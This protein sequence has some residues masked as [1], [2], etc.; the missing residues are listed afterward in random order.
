LSLNVAGLAVVPDAVPDVFVVRPPVA[1]VGL[2]YVGL[3]TG[4]ALA[5]RGF[6]VIGIDSSLPR[7]QEIREGRA[8][9]LERDRGR[10]AEA[11]AADQLRL[12]GTA[13][14]MREADAVL[15]C[16][17][18]PVDE[19]LD[20]DLRALE[21]ACATVVEHARAGQLI[22]LTST[23]YVG[24]TRR[25]LV[26]PLRER[27]L[28]AGEDVFLAF[29]PERINP[30]DI[31]HE[32]ESVPRVFGAVTEACAARTREVLQDITPVLHEVPS[33]EHA[34]LTKL[35]E[36]TYRAVNIALA[37]EMA[38][39]ARHYG[40]DPIVVTNAAATKPYGF[41]AHF[42][43]P[44]VG[45][46]CIP[47]DPYYL[48]KPLAEEGHASPLIE[49]AMRGIAERPD[50]V[51]DRA[52]LMLSADGLEIGGARVLVVGVTYKPGVRDVRESVSIKILKELI[53]RGADVS[54]YDP[55]VPI[56]R[57]RSDPRLSS[58]PYPDP[59]DY[60]AVI[61]TTQQ[62]DIDYSW[63]E[64]CDRVLDCTYRMR[65][66]GDQVLNVL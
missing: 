51:V 55:L 4:I 14:A 8:D 63:L 62:P 44:G 12:H 19:H 33:P 17:P 58:V 16:V 11:L 66:S 53:T 34:E 61:V 21:G 20:P 23:S 32:Q 45:G 48:L 59:D 22:V 5:A 27:G 36:N 35:Y 52:E 31:E 40:V 30:G 38:D 43:G 15:I 13:E 24:T 56:L 6:P 7:L 28:E 37:N 26:D 9:L 65:A 25:L 64:R 18:T 10:L 3:P 46:H 2:G 41:L 49:Q 60:A 47:C 29:A 1:I 50:H 42:P 54:Y 57:R 39:I